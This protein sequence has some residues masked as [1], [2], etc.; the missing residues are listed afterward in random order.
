MAEPTLQR[1][2]TPETRLK[3]SVASPWQGGRKWFPDPCR[4][5]A[6]VPTV[7][8]TSSHDRSGA[9]NATLVSLELK[10]LP[11]HVK[12]CHLSINAVYQGSGLSQVSTVLQ[13][14]EL[15][16][17]NQS[18]VI[19]DACRHSL[20]ERKASGKSIS[21]LLLFA[22]ACTMIFLMWSASEELANMASLRRRS[23]GA[24]QVPAGCLAGPGRA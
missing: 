22:A 14:A 8:K 24:Q 7:L 20:N 1:R 3:V 9:R 5:R 17:S 19:R 23:A 18:A 2:L 10:T 12:P 13:T 4:C 6:A 11:D 16:V 15:E 21:A